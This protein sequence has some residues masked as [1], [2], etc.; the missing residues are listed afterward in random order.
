M[1]SSVKWGGADGS[2]QGHRLGTVRFLRA[3]LGPLQQPTHSSKGESYTF[4]I[5]FQTFRVRAGKSPSII[6]S[7][8]L[9]KILIIMKAASRH[10]LNEKG[11]SVTQHTP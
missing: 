2:A 4:C 6:K 5:L 7:K 11:H 3:A 10:V 1:G 9:R 8:A